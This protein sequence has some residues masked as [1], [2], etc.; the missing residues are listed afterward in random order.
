M[1]TWKLNIRV[2]VIIMI[3]TIFI[4]KFMYMDTPVQTSIFWVYRHRKHVVM[5]TSVYSFRPSVHCAHI[6]YFP[7][8]LCRCIALARSMIL[9]SKLFVT[10]LFCSLFHY[11]HLQ[12][13]DLCK[14]SKCLFWIIA[15]TEVTSNVFVVHHFFPPALLRRKWWRR[16]ILTAARWP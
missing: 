14:W 1:H 7:Y 15:F 2:V 9:T 11:I 13:F 12:Y 4:Y 3:P 10:L 8:F 6:V 16:R 5:S